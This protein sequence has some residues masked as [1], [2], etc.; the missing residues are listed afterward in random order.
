MSR[1]EQLIDAMTSAPTQEVLWAIRDERLA[2]TRKWGEQNHPDGTDARMFSRE[3]STYRTMCDTKAAM[4]R[5]T[6]SDILL[7]EVYEALAE[8][9]PVALEIELVQ[10][11][12]VAT[13]WVEASRRRR[14]RRS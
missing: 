7:E 8:E 1:I 13:A 2:Q 5:L 4:G 6:W 3:A 14:R 12:A 11:A 10:V 9:D